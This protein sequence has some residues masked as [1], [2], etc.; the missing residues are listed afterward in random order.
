MSS[1]SAFMN[2]VSMDATDGTNTFTQNNFFESSAR[3]TG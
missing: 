2:T 3:P 1:G